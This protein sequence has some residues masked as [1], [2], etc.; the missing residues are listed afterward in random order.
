MGNV[1]PGRGKRMDGC[2]GVKDALGH[3]LSGSRGQGTIGV[4]QAVSTAMSAPHQ[5]CL[6]NHAVLHS[7]GGTSRVAWKARR[8]DEASEF[9]WELKRI[10]PVVGYPSYSHKTKVCNIVRGQQSEWDAL[11]C[12]MGWSKSL[13]W[14]PSLRSM[15]SSGGTV[16]DADVADAEETYWCSTSMLILL[17]LHW[18]T[19]HG[20][21][22]LWR[23]K[24]GE[25]GAAFLHNAPAHLSRV[26]VDEDDFHPG[27]CDVGVDE[28]N[29]LCICFERARKIA[30]ES[31]Q[32][33]SPQESTWGTVREV[34]V[35][36]RNCPAVRRILGRKIV[37]LGRHIDDNCQA[38]GEFDLLR[39]PQIVHLNAR[40]KRTRTD[41]D[42]KR[43]THDEALAKKQFKTP[44]EAACSSKVGSKRSGSRWGE[45]A[46]SVQRA[47]AHL[48]PAPGIVSFALDAAEIGN[49]SRDLLFILTSDSHHG[50]TTIPAPV[51]LSAYPCGS[52]VVK[53]FPGRKRINKK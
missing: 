39:A 21:G 31:R 26:H 50:F 38:W 4:S 15:I 36:A 49:P 1:G 42:A 3:S 37:L 18:N 17:L 30:G 47:A 13:C 29:R 22:S 40:G 32:D 5:A 53:T 51:Q 25:I 16:V 10:L 35:Q 19:N 28:N 20:K 27:L 43:L 44:A 2:N 6:W 12:A 9:R 52:D 23:S 8:A 48:S 34:F 7:D 24:V 41:V 33:V 46:L 14:A 11:I 45:S